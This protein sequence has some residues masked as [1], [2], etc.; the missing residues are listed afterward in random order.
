MTPAQRRALEVLAEGPIT[1]MGPSILRIQQRVLRALADAGLV[2]FR[3]YGKPPSW[4]IT[5]AGRAALGNR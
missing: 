4:A 5:P 1:E 3:P 2:R